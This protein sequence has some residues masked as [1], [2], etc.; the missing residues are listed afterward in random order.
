MNKEEISKELAIAV[1]NEAIIYDIYSEDALTKVILARL[2]EILTVDKGRL[3]K[4][5]ITE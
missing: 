3:T 4:G 2:T 1:R 5:T